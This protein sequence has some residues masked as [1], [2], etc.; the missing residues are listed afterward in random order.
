MYRI[1]NGRV[2]TR[3]QSHLLLMS[4]YIYLQS[5]RCSLVSAVSILSELPFFAVVLK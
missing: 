5:V 3:Q 2:D 4:L 1:P